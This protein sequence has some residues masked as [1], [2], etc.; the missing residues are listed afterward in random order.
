MARRLEFQE[1]GSDKFW[2]VSVEG[3]EVV[4]RWGRVGTAG[5]TQRKTQGSPAAAQAEADKQ[6]QGKLKKGYREVSAGD[7]AAS[8]LPAPTPPAAAPEVP[9]PAVVAPTA[10]L[11][12]APA[13][14]A[15]APAGVGAAAPAPV[16]TPGL[17][18]DWDQGAHLLVGPGGA[19]ARL[20]LTLGD[21]PDPIPLGEWVWVAQD[22]TRYP[23]KVQL[24]S[25]R[26]L[27]VSPDGALLAVLDSRIW[28]YGRGPKGWEKRW[29][30]VWLEDPSESRRAPVDLAF[31]ADGRRA[32]I[33]V[34]GE[35]GHHDEAC[36]V[37]VDAATGAELG[38]RSLAGYAPEALSL[39][40]D[41]RAAVV[42]GRWGALPSRA[43]LVGV[44]GGV[45]ALGGPAEGSP[46]WSPDGALLAVAVDGRAQVF[47]ADGAPRWTGPACRGGLG[48]DH[49]CW[50]IVDAALRVH[51]ETQAELPIPQPPL[52]G[53]VNN[54]LHD[55]EGRW[56][57][58]CLAYPGRVL[59]WDLQGRVL[60]SLPVPPGNSEM[61]AAVAPGG[62]LVAAVNWQKKVLWYPPA[63]RAALVVDEAAG[64]GA[65]WKGKTRVFDR[66]E[67]A[68]KEAEK[69]LAAREKKGFALVEVQAPLS[70]AEAEEQRRWEAVAGLPK[71]A[72]FVRDARP[73]RAA[74]PG[75]TPVGRAGGAARLAPGE[76]WPCCPRCAR[77]M[78]LM[79]ELDEAAP[80][81]GDG[82]LQV[83][84]CTSTEPHCEVETEAFFAGAGR[85]K[86]IRVLPKAGA[87]PCP[88]PVA[89]APPGEDGG[90]D[91]ALARGAPVPDLPGQEAL[92]EL[93]PR[94]AEKDD[95]GELIEGL[96]R[97]GDKVGGWPA[98]VQGVEAPPCPRCAAPM[99]QLRAQLDSDGASGWQWGDLGRAYVLGC[100]AHPDEVDLVWQSG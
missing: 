84:Y 18:P 17:R 48:W 41:G 88:Y 19:Q 82:L 63:P 29:D 32:V 1:G 15:P 95:L 70:E 13:P 6:A 21:L 40:P 23:H 35:N 31:S 28:V 38:R 76:A 87:A 43:L 24:G 34:R 3:D 79:L 37:E 20:T 89:G 46:A 69:Q 73:L 62:A 99:D 91:L 50:L 66:P 4:T 25:L 93:A 7:L 83:F 67:D 57:G 61:A 45:R 81:G 36:L 75:D 86:L 98:W 2:E 60:R 10:R 100:A 92:S 77:P 55:P 47:A 80:S 72:A 94:L 16:A 59:L 64:P 42:T 74:G 44:D 68:R 56:V 53:R 8:E 22:G 58:A 49:A 78:R 26:G 27:R 71:L 39:H 30:T 12:A 14:T 33:A 52:P 97:A 51:P 85:S 9:A 11:K 65:P 54:L 90:P 5:Q 96:P